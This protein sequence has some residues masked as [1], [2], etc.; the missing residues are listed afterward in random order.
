MAHEMPNASIAGNGEK[1]DH[2]T[3]HVESHLQTLHNENKHLCHKNLRLQ[4]N[5][6]YW[7]NGEKAKWTEMLRILLFIWGIGYSVFRF[8]SAAVEPLPYRYR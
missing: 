8:L 6:D 3:A 7:K 4:R 5:V 2:L 1:L